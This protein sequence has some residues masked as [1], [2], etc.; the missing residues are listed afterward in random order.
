M[1]TTHKVKPEYCDSNVYWLR[2]RQMMDAASVALNFENKGD[3][4]NYLNEAIALI[5]CTRQIKI[6]SKKRSVSMKD[7]ALLKRSSEAQATENW[8]AL[9]PEK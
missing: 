2:A 1:K 4:L 6:Q 9:P 5:K 7:F 8:S 3:A